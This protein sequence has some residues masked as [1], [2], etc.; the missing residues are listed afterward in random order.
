MIVR[1]VTMT[2]DPDRVNDFNELFEGVKQK[3]R[4]FPG[5]HHL[6]LL[7]GVA[8]KE[9]VFMTYSH[10]DSESDLDAYRH[11]ELFG[12]TW[13]KTKAMFSDKPSAISLEEI[14]RLP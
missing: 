9:N 11:S 5:C 6:S 13:T 10:W 8:P 1:I 2:F 12:D 7:Q 14:Q 3:I 4:G